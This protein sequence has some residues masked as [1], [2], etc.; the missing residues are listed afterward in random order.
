MKQRNTIGMDMGDRSHSI[1]ILDHNGKVLSRNTVANTAVALR[2]CFKN[3][4]PVLFAIEAGTHSAWVSRVLEDMGHEVLVGN[5][6]KLRAIWDSHEKS[7][8]RDAEMLARIARVDPELLYPIKHRNREAQLDLLH[9]KGRDLLVKIR[10]MHVSHIRSVAKGFGERVSKCSIKCFQRRATEELSAE[11]LAIVEPLL[12]CIEDL[13]LKIAEYEKRINLLCIEK[14]PETETLRAVAGVGPITA[15]AYVLTIEDPQRFK[16]SRDV[17]PF[18]GL[19]PRRDQSGNMDKQLSITKAGNSDLRRLLV[20]CAQ[21][22]LG[23]FGPDCEL[24]EFGLKLA[25]RGGK[26]AKRRA[27]VAVARKLSILLH[28]LW[29]D[30]A[31]YDPCHQR[32]RKEMARAAA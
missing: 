23:S 27:V 6:R 28:R 4:K 30:G 3:R 21:Y 1:C 8:V 29:I 15:L 32:T 5:P 12:A 10:K 31:T 9:I 25:E 2:K 19:V 11:V 7:D 14:Y 24:R 20:G 26:N 13:D 17:G 18:L 16:K 22:I